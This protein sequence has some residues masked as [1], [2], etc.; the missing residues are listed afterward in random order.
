MESA[1]YAA[2]S[3]ILNDRIV[4]FRMAKITPT[5]VGQFVTFWKRKDDEITVPY[6]TADAF[7]S[8]II[9]TKTLTQQGFFMVPKNVLL[10]YDIVSQNGK[11]GK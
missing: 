3:F 7:D 11:G 5:K 2:C 9:Y 4:Y 6:D 10:A 8:L 1:E